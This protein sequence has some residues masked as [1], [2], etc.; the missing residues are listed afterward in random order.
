MRN[1]EDH[2]LTALDTLRG[3]IMVVMAL[4]HANLFIARQHPQPEMWMGGRR[5]ASALAFHGCDAPG[6]PGFLPGHR[7]STARGLAR[8][9]G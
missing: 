2:R 7:H 3:V 5:P 9:A 1:L 4:D 6:R 8:R